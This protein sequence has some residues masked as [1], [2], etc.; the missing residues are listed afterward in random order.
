[1]GAFHE[2][3]GQTVWIGRKTYPKPDW[4]LRDL[5]PGG[6][7]LVPMTDGVDATG[8]TEPVIRAYITRYSK[9]TYT[10]HHVHRVDGGLLVM[11]STSPHIRLTRLR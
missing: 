5:E 9:T 11:R 1:M 10:K 4:P 6:S 2:V 3:E 7:F 8:R